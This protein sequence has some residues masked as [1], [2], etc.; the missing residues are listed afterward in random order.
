M[1]ALTAT[2]AGADRRHGA[3]REA[4]RARDPG[5]RFQRVLRR[6]RISAIR[7]R[8]RCRAYFYDRNPLNDFP[9]LLSW[10]VLVKSW[11]IVTGDR[12]RALPH[13]CRRAVVVGR[14]KAL[15]AGRGRQAARPARSQRAVPAAAARSR[16]NAGE[17]P[18]ATCC[19]SSP[20]IRRPS[21]SSSGRPTRS[22][23]GPTSSSAGSSTCRSTSSAGCSTTTRDLPQRPRRRPAGRGG[24]HARPRPLHRP[25][26]FRAAGQRM[27]DRGGLRRALSRPR[28]TTSRRSSATCA[29]RRS[30]FDPAA[31]GRP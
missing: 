9:Y 2:R 28:P 6:A 8:A 31:L 15:R 12:Q 30:A 19:R 20:R 1:P 22:S 5:P 13:G 11:R 14:R 16:G 25:L 29:G 3:G 18:P 21:S 10:G 17:L 27:A 24:D 4:A 26:P 7:S 23:C